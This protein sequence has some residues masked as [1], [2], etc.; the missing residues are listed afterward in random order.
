M[1]WEWHLIVN[2]LANLSES[3]QTH[4]VPL[5][6]PT[7]WTLIINVAALVTLIRSE[8]TSK[9]SRCIPNV[10]LFNKLKTGNYIMETEI[11]YTICVFTRLVAHQ[12]M[13]RM[14]TEP[15]HM[16]SGPGHVRLASHWTPVHPK[17]ISRHPSGAHVSHECSLA[18]SWAAHLTSN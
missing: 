7:A 15:Q 3:K 9:N 11:W 5:C 2:Y 18:A 14:D 13:T 4:R 12:H 16:L 6:F 8:G 17:P 10:A 1:T